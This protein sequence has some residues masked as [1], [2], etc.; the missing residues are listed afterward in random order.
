MKFWECRDSSTELIDQGVAD[1]RANRDE[2]QNKRREV[3]RSAIHS[4]DVTAVVAAVEGLAVVGALK[5]SSGLRRCR[6]AD[7]HC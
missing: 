4:D 7:L 2:E 6:D 1:E 5:T 3:L